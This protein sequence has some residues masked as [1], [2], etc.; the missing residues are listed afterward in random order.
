MTKAAA[1]MLATIIVIVLLAAMFVYFLIQLNA[2]EKEIISLQQTV[3]KDAG[4]I[5]S[6][7]NF[8]NTNAT[9]KK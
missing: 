3:S 8:L 5:S 2:Q 9:A 1:N 7:I 4:Q 6:V